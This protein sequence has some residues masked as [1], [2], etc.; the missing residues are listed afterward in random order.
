MIDFP[1][2]AN[3][4]K[5]SRKTKCFMLFRGLPTI[6]KLAE[7]ENSFYNLGSYLSNYL[8]AEFEETTSTD[9]AAQGISQSVT[10]WL[11]FSKRRFERRK[12][13]LLSAET[14][15]K[16]FYAD[17][18]REYWLDKERELLLQQMYAEEVLAEEPSSPS[19]QEQI[20]LGCLSMRAYRAYCLLYQRAQTD[21]TLNPDGKYRDKYVNALIQIEDFRTLI[22]YLLD[23]G[24]DEEAKNRYLA[25]AICGIFNDFHYSQ[26]AFECFSERFTVDDARLLLQKQMTT[27]SFP[28]ITALIAI[29][30]HQNE[31]FKARY[32]YE[33]FHARAEIGNTRIYAQFRKLFDGKTNHVLQVGKEDNHYNVL[34][35]AFYVLPPQRLLQFL[36]WASEIKIPDMA[37]YNPQ[38][39]HIR[40]MQNFLKEPG[41]I[42][43]WQQFIGGLSKRL[44]QYPVNAWLVCVC[45]GVLSSVWNL[46]HSFDVR[47]AYE[48]VLT[49]IQDPNIRARYFPVGLMAYITAYIIRKDDEQLCRSLRAVVGDEQLW[50]RL[51]VHNAWAEDSKSSLSAFSAYCVR[52]VKE[53]R[54]ELYADLLKVTAPSVSVDNLLAIASV[55]GNTDYLIRQL[56]NSYLEGRQASESQAVASQIDRT[57]LSFR[58]IEALELLQTIYSDETDLLERYPELFVNEEAAYAFKQDCASILQYYPNMGGLRA[59]EENCTDTRYKRFVYSYVFGIFYNKKLYDKY[60]FDYDAF[61]NRVDQVIIAQFLRKVFY[62]QLVYNASYDFFYKRWRYLKL[63]LTMVIE[64][65]GPA[66]ASEII[67]VMKAHRHDDNVL[68]DFFLPFQQAV[69]A[70]LELPS[71][72]AEEKKRFLY[73]VMMGHVSEY[74]SDYSETLLTRTEEETLPMKQIISMLDYRDVSYAIYEHYDSE[75][76]AGVFQ[77]AKGAA[78]ALVPAAFDALRELEAFPKRFEAYSVFKCVQQETPAQ[79]VKGMLQLND[80]QYQDYHRLIDPLVCS[81]Q[82]PFQMYK[83]FHQLVLSPQERASLERYASLCDYLGEKIDRNAPTVFLYL[84]AMREGIEGNREG[85]RTRLDKIGNDDY[86]LP[87]SW[88]EEADSLRQFAVGKRD[89]FHATTQLLDTSTG[90]ARAKKSYHFCITLIERLAAEKVTE[91]LTRD[92]LLAAWRC[93]R[94]KSG[95]VSESERIIAG[96]Q[97]LRKPELFSKVIKGLDMSETPDKFALD[98]GMEVLQ[99]KSRLPIGADDRME[100]IAELADHGLNGEVVFPQFDKLL[101]S[102]QCSIDCWCKYRNAIRRFVSETGYFSDDTFMNLYTEVLEPCAEQLDRLNALQYSVEEWYTDLEGYMATLSAM[103]DSVFRRFLYSAMERRLNGIRNGVR[104][105]IKAENLDSNITDGYVYFSIENNGNQSVVPTDFEIQVQGLRCKLEKNFEML[106]PQYIIGGRA[107]LTAAPETDLILQVIYAGVV[108]SRAILRRDTIRFHGIPGVETKGNDLYNVKRAVQVFGREQQLTQLRELITAES[109]ALIYGPSRIGKTSILDLVR[110][111]LAAEKGNVIAVTFAGEGSAKL[112]DY[113]EIP[114]NASSEEIEEHLLAESILKAFD[115]RGKRLQR[116]SALPADAEAEICD[117]LRQNKKIVV[118][119]RILNEYLEAQG[120]ELW[121]ILDEFQQAV[122][123]WTPK[124]TGAFASICAD[125]DETWRIKLIICGSDELLKHMV[126]NRSSIWRRLLPPDPYGVQVKALEDRPFQDML[127]TE[128]LRSHR[129]VSDAGISYSPEALTALYRYTGGVPLYGKH[130]GNQV[131]KTLRESG[132]LQKRNVIYTADITPATQILI[133]EQKNKGDI[134]TIYDDVKKGLDT[135]SD[136]LFLAYIAK[137]MTDNRVIGCPYSAFTQNPKGAFKFKNEGEEPYKEF[138]DSLS[139][140]EARG[141][142]KK[143]DPNA[144]D[145]CYTFCTV[146]YYYAFLG[147]AKAEFHLEDKLFSR[148]DES[149]GED[150]GA[151]QVISDYRALPPEERDTALTLIWRGEKDDTIK[152]SFRDDF[153]P[154]QT[155]IEMNGGDVV[156]GNKNIAV[157]QNITNTL[158]GIFAATGD[159]GKMLEGLQ[160]LPRLSSYLPALASGAEKQEISESQLARGINN[161]AADLEEGVEAA[162]E[163]TGTEL[164]PLWDIL[165]LPNDE[166]KEFMRKYRIPQCFLDSLQF[167][168]QLGTLFKEGSLGTSAAEIDYSPATIMYC[169]LVESMLKEYHTIPYSRAISSVRTNLVNNRRR[170]EKYRWGD[171]HKLP[172]YQQQS[173]TIGSFVFPIVESNRVSAE[174]VAD[175]IADLA[176]DTEG[177]VREWEQHALFIKA[178]RDIRNPSAHGNRNQRITEAQLDNIMNL[179]IDEGGFLR[180]V[181]LVKEPI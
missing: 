11:A 150:F 63:Y 97:V 30:I 89:E 78:A 128:P 62:A 93:Y 135:E 16:E 131:L 17:L 180:L 164:T 177:T 18:F 181:R 157:V 153:F 85:V 60:S 158:N 129:S 67:S 55:S 23:A 82:F 9:L 96:A 14:G 124:E 133:D 80:S 172:Q 116:P 144:G 33:I 64:A 146:F 90:G 39:A 2:M 148:D 71:I 155:R 104:L 176:D 142:I 50:N 94:D 143:T 111:E 15:R 69:D 79:C 86:R 151:S 6:Q 179:L 102:D 20:L 3:G 156:T 84:E 175:N 108:L 141:I 53:T 31:L 173:L 81:R 114:E 40:A 38:H 109:K 46:E 35:T 106:H 28:V 4:Q 137:Y 7:E 57:S 174:M 130:I 68:E 154:P 26:K 48:L 118:R 29:Y 19:E 37:N 87:S 24:L 163:Q 5:V 21:G 12:Q 132:D 100:I 161:Y 52:K 61:Q 47:R 171:I 92:A 122:M 8:F 113:Q 105:S 110:K 42:Q 59:F 159:P 49:Q 165:K 115:E 75:L 139:I 127:R 34:Q 107:K 168:Y 83:R 76:R 73:C 160:S 126:L 120:L 162:I 125:L 167:A 147:T 112:S 25:K 138:D 119:Y 123:R 152:K 134:S 56:C 95:S 101:R 169:K 70:Y 43:Y 13:A 145:P 65:G 74:L 149:V 58:D 51:F 166:Y 45:D 27:T 10:E 140:A 99:T 72:H 54:D 44:T 178:V 41:N 22:N 103:K 170:P 1:T 88:K 66:D 36:S 117:I 91:K 136:E 32:L 77:R 98:L 121:L